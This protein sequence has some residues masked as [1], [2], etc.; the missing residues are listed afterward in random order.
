[1][2]GSREVER[3]A[4]PGPECVSR[5]ASPQ[6]LLQHAVRH[7]GVGANPTAG[8]RTSAAPNAIGFNEGH[9]D[10]R[11]RKHVGGCASGQATADDHHVNRPGSMM[12][13]I[14][15]NSRLWK[16]VDPGGAPVASTHR[17]LI[18]GHGLHEPKPS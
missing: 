5:G 4:P 10:S 1:A 9:A 13:W 16:P 3:S 6:R 14:G 15:R 12:L 2:N 17:V 11:G 7:T 8:R 18:L